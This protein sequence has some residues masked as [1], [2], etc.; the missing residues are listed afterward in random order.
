MKTIL[1]SATFLPSASDGLKSSVSP[2]G[3][4]RVTRSTLSPATLATMSPITL[5][6][7]T[8]LIL[9]S[10]PAVLAPSNIETLART[11]RN[12]ARIERSLF[13]AFS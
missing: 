12:R 10:A 6:V 13:M 4:T 9:S 5:N 3:P 11:T 7:A 2:A 1:A 8:T